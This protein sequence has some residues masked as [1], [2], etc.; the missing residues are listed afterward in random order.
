M[1]L[2]ILEEVVDGK[3]TGIGAEVKRTT[4][5]AAHED[6]VEECGTSEWEFC[7]DDEIEEACRA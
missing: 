1:S 7:G 2:S 4:E 5:L 3:E 6:G